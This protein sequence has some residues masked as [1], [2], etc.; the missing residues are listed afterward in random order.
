MTTAVKNPRA[1]K[2]KRTLDIVMLAF[3]R[4]FPFWGVMSERCSFSVVEGDHFCDTA[5]IDRSGNII[6]NLDFYE[7]LTDKQFLFLVAHEI[8]HFIFEHGGRR[9]DR[10]P[11][12]WNMATDFA[13]NLMLKFQ[14]EKPEFLIQGFQHRGK[15]IQI[16]LDEK[17]EDMTAER[18]YEELMKN[19]PPTSGKVFILD[20]SDDE[21]G[22]GDG[23]G[24]Q[25]GEGDVVLIRD[26][27]V[28]LPEKP[29]AKNGKTAEQYKQ[30]MKDYVRQAVCEAYACAK[31][32][33]SMPAGMERV[34]M[35]HLKPKVNWLQALRQKLRMG[36]SRKASRDITWTV[37]NRRFLS[38]PYIFPSNIGPDQ[39]RIA[40]AIDTS[41]S[42][43][44]QDLKQAVSELEDIRRKFNAKVYFLDCDAG[45]YESRWIDPWEPLPALQG[46]GGTDFAPVFSHLVEK[47]IRPD[48]CVFFTDGYGNFGDDPTSK[49]EVLWVLTNQQVNPP[50]GDVVRVAV[51]NESN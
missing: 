32:Q 13:I 15:P 38:A 49:F 50:F 17:Y 12:L 22:D 7:K 19:P 11:M 34:I 40:F 48:Y 21:N 39:P 8:C 44:E 37:P 41:G 28:P 36:A 4:E 35:G 14:F 16:C 33:G 29:S 31:T 23:D 3:A 1:D 26:R 27:R 2:F 18:I 25:P 24:E 43:S 47:R 30:E 9:G 20:L 10:D 6:F 45:V 5:C 46:G 51:D 42:M